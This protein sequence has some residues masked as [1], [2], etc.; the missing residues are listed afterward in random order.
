MA[1]LLGSPCCKAYECLRQSSTP[2]PVLR[3]WLRPALLHKFQ[4]QSLGFLELQP[5]D[6]TQALLCSSFSG[7]IFPLPTGQN[8][9]KKELHRS[10]WVELFHVPLHLL[11]LVPF[12]EASQSNRSLADFHKKPLFSNCRFACVFKAQYPKP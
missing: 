9:P 2:G 7:S 8:K 1:K 5:G 11:T 12:A 3:R 6:I 10:P 4:S